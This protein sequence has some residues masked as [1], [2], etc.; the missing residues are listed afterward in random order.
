MY[1]LSSDMNWQNR[2]ISLLPTTTAMS[3]FDFYCYAYSY[4][5]KIERLNNFS[6]FTAFS[7]FIHSNTLH[8]T[9]RFVETRF[10]TIIKYNSSWQLLAYNIK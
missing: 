9:E 8:C 5:P 3:V 7:H 10:E 1:S 2:I 4:S 6:C